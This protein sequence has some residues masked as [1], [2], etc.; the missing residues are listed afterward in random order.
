MNYVT[1]PWDD[2]GQP[3]MDPS[4]NVPICNV[5][6]TDIYTDML[7]LLDPVYIIRIG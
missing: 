3:L 6:N 1:L 5:S 4:V 7:S 2:V